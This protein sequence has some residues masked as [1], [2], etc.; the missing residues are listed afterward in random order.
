MFIASDFVMSGYNLSKDSCTSITSMCERI[1]ISVY[2]V[3][4]ELKKIDTWPMNVF[5]LEV[6]ARTGA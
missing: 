6:D 1:I 3:G 2:V 4:V 5:W